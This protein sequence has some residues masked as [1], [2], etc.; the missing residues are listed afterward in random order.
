MSRWPVIF[1]VVGILTAGISLLVGGCDMFLPANMLGTVAPSS[2]LPQAP[3]SLQRWSRLLDIGGYALAGLLLAASIGLLRRRAWSVRAAIYWAAIKSVF[4]I[5][6]TVVT[7]ITFWRAI[8][9]LQR[10]LPPGSLTPR[11]TGTLLAGV[12]SISLVLGLST[13]VFVLV[14]FRRAKIRQEV[15]TWTSPGTAVN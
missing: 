8:P 10:Q 6:D 13:P 9:W 5:G 14:W 3:S 2:L 11:V 4:A 7:T 1:G 15:A 12:V